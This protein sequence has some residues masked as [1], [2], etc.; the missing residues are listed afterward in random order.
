[1]TTTPIVSI[2]D[3]LLAE[4]EAAASDSKLNIY[5]PLGWAHSVRCGNHL[6]TDFDFLS[7]SSPETILALLGHITDLKQQLVA[8][9]ITAENCELFRKDS[10]RLDWLVSEDDCVVQQGTNG[11][12]LQWIDEYDHSASEYQKGSYR[13]S[14]EA[15]DAAMVDAAIDAAMAGGG[16]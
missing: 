11:F 6:Q 15:I 1:M 9:G 2:N 12:W 14:R 4:I 16:S 5:R 10:E 13:T 3:E 8:A 7:L